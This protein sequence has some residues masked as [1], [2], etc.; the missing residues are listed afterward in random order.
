MRRKS[1][2]IMKSAAIFSAGIA[3]ARLPDGRTP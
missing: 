3:G 2:R 1:G